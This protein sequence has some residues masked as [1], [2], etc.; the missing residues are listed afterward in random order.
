M[1]LLLTPGDDGFEQAR[2]PWNRAVDQRPAAVAVPAD[3]QEAAAVVRQARV[4]GLSVA[5]Q[6]GGHGA[7][8]DVE[9]AVLLRTSRLDRI[10]LDPDARTVRVG[11]GVQWGEVLKAAAPYGLTGLAGSS[12]VVSV[13]GYTLGGGLSWFSRRHGL[14]CDSVRSFDIVD[15]EGVARTVTAASDPDLFWALR[16]GGGNFALVTAVEFDLHPAPALYGGRV[17]WPGER[18]A[19]VVEAFQ[20]ITATAPDELTLWLDLLHFPGAPP[21]VAVDVTFLGTPERAAALLRPLED[22]GGVIS[23]SRGPMS[24]ADLGAITA[25]PTEPGAGVSR[26]ELLTALPAESLLAA[27]I[28]PLL[29]VQIRHLGG[30]LARPGTASAAGRIAEPYALYLF[31]LPPAEPVRRR[32]RELAESLPVSGRKPYTFLAPGEGAAAAFDEESLIRLHKTK[33]A[34]DPDHVF[35][36]NFPL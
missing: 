36:A 17:L 10:D 29:S 5:V 18:A 32:Q 7:S 3:A 33:L 9:N 4:R 8:G 16:G 15:A 21:M 1:N 31:G 24:P 14:A 2:L 35:R 27:P 13:V 34:Y 28:E 26:G 12:P 23:D 30:A 11:A 6:A 25:E 22:V 19:R 20:R